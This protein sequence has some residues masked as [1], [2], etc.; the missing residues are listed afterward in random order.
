MQSFKLFAAYSVCPVLIV[1]K[2]SKIEKFWKA[3]LP[4]V[5]QKGTKERFLIYFWIWLLIIFVNISAVADQSKQFK[6]FVFVFSDLIGV[7]LKITR[8]L[9][10]ELQRYKQ[11]E[12][13]YKINAFIFSYIFM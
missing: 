11:E 9:S 4:K 12:V 10:N 1:K 6:C 3:F 2:W 5:G 7:L 13:L 8:W